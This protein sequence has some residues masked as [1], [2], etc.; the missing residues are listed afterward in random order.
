V[1]AFGIWVRDVF[2]ALVL[3][4]IG[5]SVEPAPEPPCP[6]GKGGGTACT[7]NSVGFQADGVCEAEER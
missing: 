4:W 3:G 5:L 7:Q 6:T 2:V 1:E